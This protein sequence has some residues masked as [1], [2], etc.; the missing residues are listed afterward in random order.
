MPLNTWKK[1]RKENPMSNWNIVFN[2][3]MYPAKWYEPADGNIGV[4]A[5][6]SETTMIENQQVPDF[7]LGMAYNGKTVYFIK[8]DC[9]KTFFDN[10]QKQEM[11]LAKGSFDLRVAQKAGAINNAIQIILDKTL[12]GRDVL[13][14][15]KLIKIAVDGKNTMPSLDKLAQEYLDVALPK[16]A[17]DEEG[18]SVRIS[19]GRYLNSDGTISYDKM[20]Q[21]Y[22]WYAGIDAI[23][24]YQ[25][26]KQILP[27]VYSICEK[28]GVDKEK[29]LSHDLQLMSDICLDIIS[30]NGM[31]I[32][33]DHLEKIRAELQEEMDKDLEVLKANGW[34]PGTG[35]SK[36]MQA[37]LGGMSE[38]S[39]PK[40]ATGKLKVSAKSLG[41]Y[42]EIDFVNSYINYVETKKLMDFLAKK[43]GEVHARYNVLVATGR[44]SSFAPN[45][46]NLPRDERIRAIFKAREGYNLASVDF[47]TVELRILSQICI[48]RY[49]FSRMGELIN[50]GKD[51]HT[52]FASKFLNCK[53]EDVPKDDRQKAKIYNFSLPGGLGPQSLSDFAWLAYQVIMSIEEAKESKQVWLQTFPEMKHYLQH[54]DINDL[55]KSGLMSDYADVTGRYG[56]DKIAAFIFKGILNGQV[57]TKSGRDYIQAEI[58]WAFD[59][60]ARTEFPNKEKYEKAISKKSGSFKLYGDFIRILNAVTFQSGRVRGNCTY[61]QSKNSPF[62]GETADGAKWAMIYLTLAGYRIVNFIHDEFIF[63]LPND[64]DIRTLEKDIKRLMIKGMNVVAPD[65]KIEAEAE[66]MINWSKSGT[67]H[68]DKDGKL[69]PTKDLAQKVGYNS[70]EELLKALKGKWDGEKNTYQELLAVLQSDFGLSGVVSEGTTVKAA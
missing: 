25:I 6:D 8:K 32:D 11:Y 2:G 40:T 48:N 56:D 28:H 36:K 65:M 46:Q 68:L 20:T 18:N 19:F 24:T 54:D 57:S 61:T 55:A 33:Q 26:A 7:I 64:G 30:S 39:L 43:E 53:E 31:K 29:L 37:I 52:F 3:N 10:Q 5:Y 66:Y 4:C 67:H 17:Q 21:P 35:S 34:V 45:M 12:L 1:T 49:G 23:A 44:T 41:K 42:K 38:V 51:L 62:Q 14:L 59:I 9:L 58:D 27:E 63:E 15:H 50:L 47:S 69:V 13:L 16:D 70:A 22:F 60:V